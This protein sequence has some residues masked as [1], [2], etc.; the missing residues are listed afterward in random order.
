M[1]QM[2]AKRRIAQ[3]HQPMTF[4]MK[5]DFSESDR[6]FVPCNVM[7]TFHLPFVF[8]IWTKCITLHSFSCISWVRADRMVK[9][10]RDGWRF[11][12]RFGNSF[13]SHVSCDTRIRRITDTFLHGKEWPFT[14]YTFWSARQFHQF[15]SISIAPV[16]FVWTVNS[17]FIIMIMSIVRHW[18]NYG[19]EEA[20]FN[21]SSM[22][23][24][25][26]YPTLISINSSHQTFW[27]RIRKRTVF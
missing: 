27:P 8:F 6:R 25:L 9:K 22:F 7:A 24:S 13:T 3:H 26:F 2:S 11:N 17:H 10:I 15:S 23:F 16:K 21:R 18:L 14:F 19:S 5:K 1:L 4:L 12:F 20:T